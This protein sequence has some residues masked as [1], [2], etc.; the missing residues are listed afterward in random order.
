MGSPTFSR[1][2]KIS[3]TTA[4]VNGI[5]KSFFP[6]PANTRILCLSRGAAGVESMLHIEVRMR[7]AR[8][9]FHDFKPISRLS[10]QCR[11]RLLVDQCLAPPEHATPV[12]KLFRGQT[13]RRQNLHRRMLDEGQN[14]FGWRMAYGSGWRSSRCRVLASRRD[15]PA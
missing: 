14:R 3:G 8:A 7:Q 4:V 2:D 5:L 6:A 12:V 11:L 9:R 15:R 10:H 1:A 13:V